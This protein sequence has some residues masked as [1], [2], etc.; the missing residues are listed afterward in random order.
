MTPSMTDEAHCYQNAVAERAN[1]ILKKDFCLNRLF[2][3]F[4][5]MK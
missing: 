3:S 2:E 5:E 4:Q 1:G